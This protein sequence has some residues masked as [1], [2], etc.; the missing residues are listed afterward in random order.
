MLG[1]M[2]TTRASSR[3]VRKRVAASW[4][5]RGLVG[6]QCAAR[7]MQRRSGMRVHLLLV[8]GLVAATISPALAQPEEDGARVPFRGSGERYHRSRSEHDWVRIASPTSTKFG[9]EYIIIGKDA[10]VFRSLRIDAVAGTVDIRRVSV[11]THRYAKRTFNVRRRLDARHPSLYI[12]L[13]A[14]TRISQ[15]VITTN[16]RVAGSFTIYGSAGRTMPVLIARR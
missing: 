7:A 1:T 9:T 16:R 5:S 2:R 3:I 15:I 14:S 4:C 10:G 8:L 12:D 11:L 6:G 13:G